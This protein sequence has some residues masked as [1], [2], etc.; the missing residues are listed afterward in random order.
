MTTATNT[1]KDI[2][3]SNGITITADDL[4]EAI[5]IADVN[6]AEA[7]YANEGSV[8]DKPFDI[9][10]FDFFEDAWDL[11]DE[12]FVEEY[13]DCDEDKVTALAHVIEGRSSI[14]HD[15]ANQAKENEELVYRVKGEPFSLAYAKLYIACERTEYTYDDGLDVVLSNSDKLSDYVGHNDQEKYE[16]YR[17]DFVWGNVEYIVTLYYADERVD[18]GE[19]DGQ[20]DYIAIV[21]KEAEK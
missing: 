8:S 17:N 2:T 7:A 12:H 18:R 19:A 15:W 16:E 11:V 9:C 3:A 13:N 4:K 5:K 1:L 21:V 14:W 6:W 20:P 10:M